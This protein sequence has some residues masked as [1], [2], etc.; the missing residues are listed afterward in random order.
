MTEYAL[1]VFSMIILSA[2]A[3]IMLSGVKTKKVARF[4][5]SL[6]ITVTLITPVVKF[7]LGDAT[8]FAFGEYELS[9][10][11]DFASYVS[12]VAKKQIENEI[13]SLL[14]NNGYVAVKEVSCTLTDSD[15][16][17]EK[18]EIII[19]QDGISGNDEHT[20]ILEIK[21]LIETNYH[22]S[23]ESVTVSGG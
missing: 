5:F 14:K 17:L 15:D 9:I 8:Q 1:S 10:D 12:S 16:H 4:V 21:S 11:H 22:L 6:I 23:K 13:L 7:F 20:Y 18:V 2:L 19:E 3:E